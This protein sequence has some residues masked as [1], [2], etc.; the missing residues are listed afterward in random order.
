MFPCIRSFILFILTA[1]LSNFLPLMLCGL[2]V[3]GEV[4]PT[5]SSS[6]SLGP[7]SRWNLGTFGSVTGC[8]LPGLWLC[9]EVC[10]SSAPRQFPS[11]VQSYCYPGMILISIKAKDHHDSCDESFRRYIIFLCSSCYVNH[12]SF[13]IFRVQKRLK[14]NGFEFVYLGLSLTSVVEIVPFFFLPWVLP[15]GCVF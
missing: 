10:Y 11:H 8:C 9:R 6:S 3:R 7:S 14:T 1:K 13:S 4:M 2:V 15:F 12:N 5:S